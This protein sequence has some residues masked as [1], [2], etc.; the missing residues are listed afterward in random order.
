M[1]KRGHQG[2][3]GQWEDHAWRL[4]LSPCKECGALA[5]S[6]CRTDGGTQRKPHQGR[7][8]LRPARKVER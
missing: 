7:D 1:G 3:Y 2:Q 4:G 8:G 5:E 6:A